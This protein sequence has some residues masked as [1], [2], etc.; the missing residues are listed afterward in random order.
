MAETPGRGGAGR[1]VAHRV[2]GAVG[3]HQF[4][5]LA[6]YPHLIHAGY[7][8]RLDPELSQRP[9]ASGVDMVLSYYRYRAAE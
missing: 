8:T 5:S 1:Q 7:G 6:I 3:Q 9:V 4:Y 2:A